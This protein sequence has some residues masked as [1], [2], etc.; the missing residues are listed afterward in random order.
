MKVFQSHPNH[1]LFGYRYIILHSDGPIPDSPANDIG[2]L[3]HFTHRDFL[4][5]NR[6][7]TPTVIVRRELSHRFPAN[8]WFA[9]DFALWT[10]TL[11]D[12]SQAVLV[13][14]TL[15]YLHKA[16]YG[17]SGLSARLREMHQGEL[18]VLRSLKQSGAVTQS[19][20]AFI[21]LWMRL[22]YLRRLTRGAN[23]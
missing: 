10:N 3:Q 15:T 9:E 5:R 11:A 18:R 20:Y 13:D 6:I 1:Q 23:V 21:N 17:H 2:E 22:K 19:N 4:I 16:A 7:S 14:Q 12:G 8:Q